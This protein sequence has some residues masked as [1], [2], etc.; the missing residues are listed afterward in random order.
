MMPIF[1]ATVLAIVFQPTYTWF[2]ARGVRDVL[3][4]LLTI[5]IFLVCII[6]PF[7]LIGTLVAQ[8]A[9][10]VYQ[11]LDTNTLSPDHITNVFASRI[12]SLGIAGTDVDGINDQLVRVFTTA[13]AWVRDAATSIGTATAITLVKSIIMLYLLFFF[14]KDGARIVEFLHYLIPIGRAREEH[15]F[16]TF[17]SVTRALFKGTLVVAL[18]QGF[19]GTCFFV[20]AGVPHAFLFG[21]LMTLFACIP[22]VGPA[23]VWIPVSVYLIAIGNVLPGLFII[24]GGT[25]IIGVI[26]NILRPIL[27][28]RDTELP[29]PLIF[30]SILGGIATFGVPG[31]ILGPVAAGL[32]LSLLQMFSDEY[33]EE[34]ER[35]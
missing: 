20:G 14:L 2:R 4:S 6:V 3:A 28:G 26:D 17:A 24:F 16:Q 27:V 34:L 23:A 30:I 7:S 33:G 13:L 15:L 35:H 22:G 10:H 12:A 21:A 8:E 9:V 25:V 18:V 1:W 11:T 32:C 29:N 19:L 5:L 31:V